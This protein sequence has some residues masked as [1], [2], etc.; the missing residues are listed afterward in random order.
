M[1]LPGFEPESM[2]PKA[3]RIDQTTPQALDRLMERILKTFM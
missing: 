2:A 1:G 3:T